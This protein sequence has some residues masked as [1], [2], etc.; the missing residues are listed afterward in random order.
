MA[1][2]PSGRQLVS[3]IMRILRTPKQTPPNKAFCCDQN[4]HVFMFLVGSSCLGLLLLPSL[5]L[6]LIQTYIIN[7]RIHTHTHIYIC[8]YMYLCYICIYV[9][10]KYILTHIYNYIYIYISMYSHF[11]FEYIYIYTC[12]YKQTDIQLHIYFITVSVGNIQPFSTDQARV[13]VS[14]FPS[15]RFI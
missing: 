10:I 3:Y 13:G 14:R 11:S 8:M 9:Y 4:C 7:F 5:L 15:E 6:L 12:I 1:E 2:F